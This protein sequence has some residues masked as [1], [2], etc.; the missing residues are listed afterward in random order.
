MERLPWEVSGTSGFP[1]FSCKS[2]VGELAFAE[3]SDIKT[4]VGEDERKE[5]SVGQK[6][7]RRKGDVDLVRNEEAVS[8]SS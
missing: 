3:A 5:K 8:L 4:G 6:G 1:S 7:P 2:L